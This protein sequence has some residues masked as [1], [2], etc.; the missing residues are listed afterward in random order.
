MRGRA[1]S[2]LC[3]NVRFNKGEKKN[4][5]ESGQAHGGAVRYLRDG[6]IRHGASRRS[7]HARSGA[8]RAEWPAPGRCWSN[9]LVA[10]EK[11]LEKPARPLMAIVAGS[12]VSTK[13]TV[14]EALL[15][16]VDQLDRR[17]RHRQ[18]LPR[19]CRASRSASRCTRRTCR[20]MRADLMAE[21]EQR[22]RRFRCPPTWSS[23]RSSPARAE[24]DVKDVASVRADEMILDIGPR[25]R[26]SDSRA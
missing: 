3:E 1:R 5:D 13:L 16:K 17:R 15:A 9:E 7:E 10:L 21:S 23:P 6:C 26:R 18:Y 14:L 19:R 25:H 11:A 2:V 22:G 24:A 20:Y 4:S 12:K 8:V